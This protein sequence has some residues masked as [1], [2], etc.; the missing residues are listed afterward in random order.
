MS[1]ARRSWGMAS[2][3]AAM[4]R[5]WACTAFASVRLG[6]EKPLATSAALASTS[7]SRPPTPARTIPA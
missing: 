2:P 1:Y 7:L 6:S 5:Q 3:S 4:R